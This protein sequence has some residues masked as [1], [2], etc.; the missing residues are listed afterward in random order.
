M[1]EGLKGSW[2]WLAFAAQLPA[3]PLIVPSTAAAYLVMGGRAILTGADLANT[4]TVGGAVVID[5][6]TSSN[7]SNVAQIGFAAGVTVN[8]RA[9]G[10]GV[11]LEQGCFLIPQG[12][13]VQG[14]MFLI[15]LWHYPGGPPGE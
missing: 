12:I 9:P 13:T 4:A 2:E 14:V 7:G 10:Q 6:G 1:I 5:D 8:Y 3:R 15:P 11:L